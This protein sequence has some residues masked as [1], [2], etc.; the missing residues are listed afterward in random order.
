[1]NK[2]KERGNR[3]LFWV[4]FIFSIAISIFLFHFEGFSGIIFLVASVITMIAAFVVKIRRYIKDG[5]YYDFSNG[6]WLW[7]AISEG[8]FVGWLIRFVYIFI[9]VSNGQM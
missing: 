3:V 8:Y 7:S 1:M 9:H 6:S 4:V 5:K 2:T